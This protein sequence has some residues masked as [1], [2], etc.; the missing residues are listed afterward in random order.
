MTDHRKKPRRGISEQ[1]F[2]S[3]RGVHQA[4]GVV[5]EGGEFHALSVPV[6]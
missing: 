4:E 3:Q 2:E 1:G 5:V 6:K